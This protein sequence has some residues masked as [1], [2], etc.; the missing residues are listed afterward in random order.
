LRR[1]ILDQFQVDNAQSWD[2]AVSAIAEEQMEDE[3]SD[4]T[5]ETAP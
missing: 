5:E 2:E 3:D 4:P 1:L